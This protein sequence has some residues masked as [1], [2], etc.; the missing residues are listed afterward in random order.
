MT[1]NVLFLWQMELPLVLMADVIAIMADGI[2]MCR[3]ECKADVIAFVVD[4][5]TTGSYLSLS[6]NKTLWLYHLPQS[7]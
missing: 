3:L 2:V 4:G 7:L 5:I 6:L 1:A